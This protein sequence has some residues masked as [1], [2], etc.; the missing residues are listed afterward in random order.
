[1]RMEYEMLV[2]R[3]FGNCGRFQ[4]PIGM[5]NA[6]I[7]DNN[8]VN[9]GI[10]LRFGISY[11]IKKIINDCDDTQVNLQLAQLDID[12]WQVNSQQDLNQVIR[13]ATNLIP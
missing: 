9:L 5:A 4:D 1:M 8:I 6:D 7:Y 11:A 3:A 2:R 10:N 12:V 13:D